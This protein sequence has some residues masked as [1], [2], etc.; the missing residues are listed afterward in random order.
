MRVKNLIKRYMEYDVEEKLKVLKFKD[1][2]NGVEFNY[3]NLILC[4]CG[5][6]LSESDFDFDFMEELKGCIDYGDYSLDD[7]YKIIV[8][9]QIYIEIM[10]AHISKLI[11]MGLKYQLLKEERE[12]IYKSLKDCEGG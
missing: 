3:S 11:Q 12:Q 5:S 4:E 2:L 9:N 10:E 1:F 6:N 7:I 8:D